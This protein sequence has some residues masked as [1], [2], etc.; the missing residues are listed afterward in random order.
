M[1]EHLPFLRRAL[2]LAERGRYRVSPNPRVGAVVARFDRAPEGEVV[3]EG[4]HA[5]VGGPHAERVALEAAGE[6]ARGAT[7]YVTLEPCAHHGRTPPCTEAIREAGI[8]RVVACHRDPNPEVAGDGFERLRDAGIEVESGVLVEEAVRL[9][10]AFLT[11]AIHRR[12]AVTLKWAMS[13]DGKIAT[14]AGD[15]QWISSPQAR[16]ASLDLREEHD[17]LLVGS[18]T[19]LADDP[20]LT[21]RPPAATS[22]S[23]EGLDEA[24]GRAEGPNVRVVLDGRL[25]TPPAARLFDEDGPVLMYT[26][27]AGAQAPPDAPPGSHAQRRRA[28]E[29][30]GAVV[31]EIPREIPRE[32][33]REPA[34]ETGESEARGPVDPARVLADL[35]RRGVRSVLVEGGGEVHASFVAAGLF[36]R[37]WVDVGPLLLGGRVAPGPLGGQGLA[38]LGDAP[39]VEGIDVRRSGDDVLINGYRP[40]C[41]QALCSSVDG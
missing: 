15:S 28:L 31:V 12:P 34:E 30:R 36:D 3:A 39:R 24:G 40:G 6:R 11:A 18:G 32:L 13:L 8:A 38:R 10:L 35:W 22:E 5:A 2:A 19:V 14:V 9:N 21:R 20:R 33:R 4:Y 1:P 27:G 16:R 41:L 17:A 7:L 25:R 26:R 29:E 23:G 37:V